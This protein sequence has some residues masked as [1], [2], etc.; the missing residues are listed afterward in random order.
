MKRGEPVNYLVAAFAFVLI[1]LSAA[2]L[3]EARAPRSDDRDRIAGYFPIAV[4][5][6]A[7]PVVKE[8][9]MALGEGVCLSVYALSAEATA[10]LAANFSDFGWSALPFSQAL[11]QALKKIF[12]AHAAGDPLKSRG[13]YTAKQG[14]YLFTDLNG[15]RIDFLRTHG[16][17]RTGAPER[18]VDYAFCIF[19]IGNR[20]LLFYVN[21]H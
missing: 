8:D 20:Q 6:D 11:K 3:C 17:A 2:A 12:D 5:D 7:V 4:P 15:K 16:A 19:D 13:F 10:R 14:Y 1:A 18:F 9:T 21:I